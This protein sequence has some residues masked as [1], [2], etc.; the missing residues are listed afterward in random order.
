M[1]EASNSLLAF[2][3]VVLDELRKKLSPA[4]FADLRK[5]CD[6]KQEGQDVGASVTPTPGQASSHGD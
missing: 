2:F 1:T 4:E 3:R 5:E 6:T